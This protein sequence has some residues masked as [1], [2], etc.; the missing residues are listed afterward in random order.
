MYKFLKQY[1]ILAAKLIIF[2]PL[3]AIFIII[4]F[5]YKVKI[6]LIETRLMGH[7][8]MHCELFLCE[9]ERGDYN[10]QKI[11][12]FTNKFICNEYIF[13]KYKKQMIVFPRFIL[14]P[15]HS[16]FSI[17]KIFHR[18]IYYVEQ[19]E[20]KT[21]LIKRKGRR[22]DPD[23]LFLKYEKKIKFTDKE[24]EAGDSFLEKNMEI[25]K[26]TDFIIFSSRN[27]IW[28]KKTYNQKKNSIRNSNINNQITAL[29]F[30]N[31]KGYKTVKIGKDH[32]KI[33]FSNQN[34]IDFS[35]HKFRN[36][37][38]EVYLVSKCK[39]MISDDSGISYFST[40]LRK[41]KLIINLFNWNWL[42][43]QS[44]KLLPIIIP[45][46]IKCLK[47]EKILTYKE[48]LDRKIEFI[49][50]EEDLK[51]E[52]YIAI[53]NTSLEIKNA[54]SNMTKLTENNLDLKNF[55]KSQNEFWSMYDKYYQYNNDDL[56]ICPNFFEENK[57]L[58]SN[59]GF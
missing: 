31:S 26:N 55:K 19:F 33:N 12:W 6:G 46:K 44:P 34:I 38:L 14:E 43:H 50:T 18:Y 24:I 23:N 20:K 22:D 56:I 1:P 51:K 47:N 59:G 54:V 53:E 7:L 36:D 5:F 57:N 3:I 29:E 30:L 48:V 49:D 28:A 52:G 2:F 42:Y 25:K 45:K 35:N 8:L 15:I 17:F 10:N 27:S 11:I 37:F 39:F 4:N 9:T 32:P 58:F 13:N 41:K 40:V 16:L 21:G